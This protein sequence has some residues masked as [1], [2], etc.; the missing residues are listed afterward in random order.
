MESCWAKE[1]GDRPLL[2]VVEPMLKSI[3][4]RFQKIESESRDYSLSEKSTHG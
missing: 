4:E 1:P 3:M 2:G